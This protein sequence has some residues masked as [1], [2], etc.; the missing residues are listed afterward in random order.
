[1]RET[2]CPDRLKKIVDGWDGREYEEFKKKV[3]P[4]MENELF[5]EFV[6]LLMKANNSF[7]K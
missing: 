4:Y 5:M 7:R 3:D 1:M 6:Q 2:E